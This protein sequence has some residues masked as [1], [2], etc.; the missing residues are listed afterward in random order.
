MRSKRYR[1]V[2]PRESL[3]VVRRG[4]LWHAAGR[5]MMRLKV[6]TVL[7]LLFGLL[8]T[9][10]AV[11]E[12]QGV[13]LRGVRRVPTLEALSAVVV[14]EGQVF[15]GSRRGLWT[16]E[17]DRLRFLNVFVEPPDELGKGKGRHHDEHEE[18]HLPD[19]RRL[20]P[21]GDTLWAINDWFLWR[22]DSSGWAKAGKGR[23]TSLCLVDGDVIGASSRELYRFRRNRIDR[24]SRTRTQE[25]I[26]DVIAMDGAIYLLHERSIDVADPTN[27]YELS[28]HWLVDP[29]ATLKALGFLQAGESLVIGTNQGTYRLP[30]GSRRLDGASRVDTAPPRCLAWGFGGALWIGRDDGAIRLDL[31]AD[32]VVTESRSFPIGQVN[33]IACSAR[34]VYAATEDGL[35]VIE[36]PA[37]P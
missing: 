37:S 3:L 15:A 34:E 32:G 23:Y 1:S 10:C 33:A 14:F 19:V 9:G 5:I 31:D 13:T 30:P 35:Y 12:T 17:G 8:G 4:P 18:H 16:L 21:F 36:A 20:L 27:H 29:Q 26:L 6:A 25:P 22:R 24:L 11:K 7:L 2:P 28:R